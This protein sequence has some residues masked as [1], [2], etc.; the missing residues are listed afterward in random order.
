MP[1][2][3]DAPVP[4][5]SSG[6]QT[7]KYHVKQCYGGTKRRIFKGFGLQRREYVENGLAMFLILCWECNVHH[8]L[9]TTTGFRVYAAKEEK[10]MSFIL[11]FKNLKKLN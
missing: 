10:K 1:K 7:P 5:F 4:T 8:W 9:T 6:G 2:D 3:V 11:L